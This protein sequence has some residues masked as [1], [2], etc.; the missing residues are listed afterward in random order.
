MDEPLEGGHVGIM[1][2]CNAK[3]GDDRGTSNA[4]SNLQY[5]KRDLK[6]MPLREMK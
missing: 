5:D 3:T 6:R 1:T 4:T 2:C